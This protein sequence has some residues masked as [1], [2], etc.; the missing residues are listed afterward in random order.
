MET[1]TLVMLLVGCTMMWGGLVIFICIAM[2]K[3]NR[4]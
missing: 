3:K 4:G 1:G 2:A